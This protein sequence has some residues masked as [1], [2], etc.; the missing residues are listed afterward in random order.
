MCPPRARAVG[1]L[2][3]RK[4]HWGRSMDDERLYRRYRELQAYV[5]WTDD[6]ADRVHA[7]VELLEPHLLSLIDDFYAEIERHPGARKVITGGRQQVERLKGTLLVWIRDLFSGRYDQD[8]VARRCT[9]FAA[10]REAAGIAKPVTMHTLRHSFA[11]HLLEAG[12]DLCTI[13]LLLGHRSLSTTAR[14]L[15]VATSTVC[16]AESPLDRLDLALPPA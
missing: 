15:H 12:T 13:Q 3:G 10:V 14:Y 2:L 5:G 9:G 11:T 8:Y 1:F 4:A 6:D 16:A 7:L